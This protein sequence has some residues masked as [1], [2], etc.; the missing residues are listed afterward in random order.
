[1]QSRCSGTS[2]RTNPSRFASDPG[3]EEAHA[4]DVAARPAEARDKSQHRPDRR[5]T[6]NDR[7][8]CGSQT[9]PPGPRRS[10]PPTMM[11]TWRI[12]HFAANAGSRSFVLPPN[13]IRSARSALDKPAS[14]SPGG[15][16][17]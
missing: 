4:G 11:V 8:C 14:F 10:L 5:H 15:M 6:H 1:M 16:P 7:N 17:A 3:A 13:G 9:W 2:S 12:D